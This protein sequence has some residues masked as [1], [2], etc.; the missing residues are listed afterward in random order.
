MYAILALSGSEVQNL[1]FL[2][3]YKKSLVR[4][5][6]PPEFAQFFG[7]TPKID[8]PRIRDAL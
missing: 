4:Y 7:K 3:I 5:Y 1:P 2:M 8:F 6:P